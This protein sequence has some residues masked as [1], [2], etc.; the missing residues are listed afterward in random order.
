MEAP[1]TPVRV[2][3]S[4]SE[5][6]RELEDP[7]GYLMEGYMTT[8]HRLTNGRNM[9][10]EFYV[11][12]QN[13]KN[14]GKR[15]PRSAQDVASTILE[16]LFPGISSSIFRTLVPGIA[17]L[18]TLEEALRARRS[19]KNLPFTLGNLED[20]E[21]WRVKRSPGISP[22]ITGTLE[23][24]LRVKRFS[25]VV[26]SIGGLAVSQVANLIGTAYLNGRVSSLEIRVETLNNESKRAMKRIEASVS[27][28]AKAI[29]LNA[30][31][32]EMGQV[33]KAWTAQLAKKVWR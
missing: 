33:M 9:I 14:M 22:Y 21:R 26:A 12:T 17:P 27:V 1:P 7:K 6:G 18:F 2:L 32:D 30:Q 29:D 3:M 25:T 16:S 24:N 13:K 20:P 5:A 31:F 23:D 11:Q 19:P 8:N 4:N 28:L 10:G 15:T